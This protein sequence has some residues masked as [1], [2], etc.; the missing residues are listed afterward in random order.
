[1]STTK[2]MSLFQQ[3]ANDHGSKPPGP[4]E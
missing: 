2:H 4:S 1:L 3:P